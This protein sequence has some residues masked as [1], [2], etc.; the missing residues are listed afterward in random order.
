MTQNTLARSEVILFQTD[1]QLLMLL[2]RKSHL[3]SEL[4]TWPALS[5]GQ[6]LHTNACLITSVTCP[7]LFR[8]RLL[9]TSWAVTCLLII[10]TR[11]AQGSGCH[12]NHQ[13]FRLQGLG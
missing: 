8:A 13:G 5:H 2:T 10:L 9:A 4:Q 1:I 7:G 11:S 6:R 3:L 12:L